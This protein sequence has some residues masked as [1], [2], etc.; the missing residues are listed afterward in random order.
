M[1]KSKKLLLYNYKKNLY[2]SVCFT[3]EG[4]IKSTYKN[5]Q[6]YFNKLQNVSDLLLCE[7]SPKTN[8]VIDLMYNEKLT[9][10]YIPKQIE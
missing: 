8:R 5:M 1:V 6:F 4:Y 3:Q 7:E 10:L 2:I 9:H